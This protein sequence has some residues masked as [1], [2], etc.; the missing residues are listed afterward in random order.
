MNVGEKICLYKERLGH[1]NYQDF[2]RA[3]DVSGDWINELSK[4]SEIKVT[5]M[6]NIIKIC[7]YLGISIDQLVKDNE[8]L[9]E[10]SIKNIDINSEDIGVLLNNMILLLRKEGTKMDNVTMN[11]KSKEV[12][13]DA[14]NV[15]RTLVKQHL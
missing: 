13:I 8:S 1:K 11:E 2:G 4:K 6:N 15:V 5:D 9:K 10:E 3:A 7:E 12:C 14:L